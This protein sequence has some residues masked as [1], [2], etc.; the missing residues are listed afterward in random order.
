VYKHQTLKGQAKFH[1]F[2]DLDTVTEISN[3][4][5]VG[6]LKYKMDSFHT[7][8]QLI[9]SLIRALLFFFTNHS[10]EDVLGFGAM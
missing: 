6:S 2:A 10:L 4:T 7:L 9:I 5:V 3:Y 8:L 1:A